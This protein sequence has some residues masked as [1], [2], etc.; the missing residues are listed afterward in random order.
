VGEAGRVPP[1]LQRDR[2]VLVP[3]EGPVAIRG[4]V[5]PAGEYRHRAGNV[6]AGDFRG[7]FD[8]MGEARYMREP[9]AVAKA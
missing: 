8:E 9:G 4:L 1:R 6:A 7:G 3:A 2:T 5:E